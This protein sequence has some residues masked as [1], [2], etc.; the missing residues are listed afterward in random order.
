[1]GG[2]PNAGSGSYMYLVGGD[3]WYNNG[4]NYLGRLDSGRLG[5]WTDGLSST[6]DRRSSTGWSVFQSMLANLKYCHIMFGHSTDYNNTQ[7]DRII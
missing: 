1:M 4:T 6:S 3:G 7:A 5:N 2:N